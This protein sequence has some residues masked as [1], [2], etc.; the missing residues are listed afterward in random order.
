MSFAFLTVYL[1]MDVVDNLYNATQIKRHYIKSLFVF[2]VRQ[3]TAAVALTHVLTEH[4]HALWLLKL[5]Y[6]FYDVMI[7]ESPEFYI[8]NC[9]PPNLKHNQTN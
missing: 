9:Q 6:N 2:G 5:S 1:H 7:R 4:Y 8:N 3:R